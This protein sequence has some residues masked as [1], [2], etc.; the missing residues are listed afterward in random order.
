M[1]RR[2]YDRLAAQEA[3]AEVLRGAL[4]IQQT[5]ESVA[6]AAT[7]IIHSDPIEISQTA[8]TGCGDHC[9][10]PSATATADDKK[11]DTSDEVMITGFIPGTGQR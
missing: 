9:I 2:Q 8:E 7:I 3:E 1:L 11:S 5:R 10:P 6:K 4:A